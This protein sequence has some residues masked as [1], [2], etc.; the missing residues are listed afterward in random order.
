MRSED[1]SLSFLVIHT[2]ASGRA[3]VKVRAKSALENPLGLL[4]SFGRDLRLKMR[5]VASPATTEPTSQVAGFCLSESRMRRGNSSFCLKLEY[6]ELRC[7]RE[8]WLRSIS[9][10]ILGSSVGFRSI[11]DLFGIPSG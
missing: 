8:A 1:H 9:S 2:F 10:W 7:E 6:S 4:L 11:R 3:A 5:L